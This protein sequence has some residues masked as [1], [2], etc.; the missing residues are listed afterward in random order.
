MLYGDLEKE[1]D[2]DEG[3]QIDETYL[4][5]FQMAQFAAQYLDHC[6]NTLSQRLEEYSDDYRGL[7][8][9]KGQLRRRHKA[10]V[11]FFSTSCKYIRINECFFVDGSADALAKGT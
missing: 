9:I 2:D 11:G 3:L 4:T 10:L 6:V 8:A 1:L 5:A 7:V